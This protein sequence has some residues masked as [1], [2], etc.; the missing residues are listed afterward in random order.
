MIPIGTL[1]RKCKAKLEGNA[2][3]LSDIEKRIKLLEEEL[4]H[5]ED[6]SIITKIDQDGNIC[7][8]TSDISEDLIIQPLS[9]NLL[10][11][12][13][14]TKKRNLEKAPKQK[15]SLVRFDLDSSNVS[16]VSNR[17]RSIG[18][19]E[20]GEEIKLKSR[21]GFNSTV[22]ELLQNYEPASVERKPFYCRVCR[23]QGNS[24]EDL[25]KPAPC[26]S[27]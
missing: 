25:G 27:F 9:Q 20:H 22:E 5:E 14:C 13:N 23:F 4:F 3:K 21:S 24:F 18:A 1:A 8:L 6:C 15:K 19:E 7:K 2:S 12:P 10:P 17:K 11:A 26:F 16:R